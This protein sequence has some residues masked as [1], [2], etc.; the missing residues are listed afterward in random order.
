MRF[1]SIAILLVC[2]SLLAGAALAVEVETVTVSTAGVLPLSKIT[3]MMPDAGTVMSMVETSPQMYCTPGLAVMDGVEPETVS[4]A[5]SI[6]EIAD[7]AVSVYV[8]TAL[9]E[10]DWV[11]SPAAFARP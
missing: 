1:R 10:A 11:L 3:S 5:D 7:F 8:P 4:G 2:L 9:L 6:W